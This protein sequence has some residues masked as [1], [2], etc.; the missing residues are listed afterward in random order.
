MISEFIWLELIEQKKNRICC[1]CSLPDPDLDSDEDMIVCGDI[2]CLFDFNSGNVTM[3][4]FL[5][6]NF[7]SL[8]VGDSYQRKNFVQTLILA[9]RVKYGVILQNVYIILTDCWGSYSGNL[10]SVDEVYRGAD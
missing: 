4:I 5:Y 7:K 2:E 10:E 3:K 1:S 9:L 6:E 8:C